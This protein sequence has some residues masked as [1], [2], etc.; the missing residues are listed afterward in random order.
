MGEHKKTQQTQTDLIATNREKA[1]FKDGLDVE[2]KE[3]D[4]E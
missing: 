2:R 3:E 4:G 1:R